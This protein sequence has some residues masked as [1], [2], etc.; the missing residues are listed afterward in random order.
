MAGEVLAV[1]LAFGAGRSIAGGREL[2]P[3]PKGEPPTPAVV[4]LPP[5]GPATAEDACD[6]SRRDSAQARIDALRAE[7]ER[8]QRRLAEIYE[9]NPAWCT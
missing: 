7:L 4:P 8:P 2:A 9:Q 3:D 1:A 6:P 5:P